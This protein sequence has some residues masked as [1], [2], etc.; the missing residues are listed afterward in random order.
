MTSFDKRGGE[1]AGGTFSAETEPERGENVE[2]LW[3]KEDIVTLS[4]RRHSKYDTER[5][6]PRVGSL[7]KEG[8][9]EARQKAKAWHE[10]VPKGAEVEIYES[11]SFMVAG[12]RALPEP[13]KVK[14]RRATI[15]ASTYEKEVFGRLAPAKM[16]KGLLQS[17]R[18]KRSYL[19]GDFVE[20]A[21]K[22]EL[23]PNFF[24]ARGKAYGSNDEKFWGD[25]VEGKL[26][27]QVQEALT[28]FGGS[29]PLDLAKNMA[30]FIAGVSGAKK[31]KSEV[32][33]IALAVTHGETM[34]S[35]LFH[36]E[37]F[38]KE[39]QGF[40]PEAKRVAIKHNEGFDA[41]IGLDG[42][43]VVDTGEGKILQVNLDEFKDYLAKAAAS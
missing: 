24:K 30:D 25:F 10:R 1:P 20:S 42:N 43:L 18:R 6:S 8:I 40:P 41:H 4:L 16:E 23:I 33:Q 29:S 32:K 3:E 22:T 7:T 15:T 35:F 13:H 2:A 27:P 34:E 31:E 14:P 17:V 19:L 5:G 11:P 26:D 21:K 9:E 38:L 36:L 37:K 28:A 39:K 12:E